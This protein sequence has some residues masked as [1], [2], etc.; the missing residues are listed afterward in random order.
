MRAPCVKVAVSRCKGVK[1]N[2][3]SAPLAA[4]C[5]VAP[6]LLFDS[7]KD[8]W[9]SQKKFGI[10]RKCVRGTRM[11]RRTNLGWAFQTQFP[12]FV[13]KRPAALEDC[14]CECYSAIRA[15]TDKMMGSA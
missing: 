3:A 10:L 15:E 9:H 6:A 1:V 12:D 2:R 7:R 4:P 8:P 14:A 5:A 11:W 13:G